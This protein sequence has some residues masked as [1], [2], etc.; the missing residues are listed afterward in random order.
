[1]QWAMTIAVV[2]VAMFMGRVSEYG[3]VNDP[4]CELLERWKM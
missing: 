2:T 1:M 3:A 4:G